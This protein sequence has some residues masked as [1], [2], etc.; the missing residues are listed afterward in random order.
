MG[1]SK[2]QEQM[3]NSWT[4][5]DNI[6]QY[7]GKVALK[8]R[9]HRAYF[10]SSQFKKRQHEEE[11]AILRRDNKDTRATLAQKTLKGDARV[12]TQALSCRKEEQL[13]LQRKTA[14]VG[15]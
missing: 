12:I 4:I 5:Y 2:G 10:E 1:P 11:I 9:D 15:T 13:A 6:E 8:E 14:E 7:R 3:S